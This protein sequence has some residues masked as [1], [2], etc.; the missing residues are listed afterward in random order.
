ML[1]TSFICHKQGVVNDE[2]LNDAIIRIVTGSVVGKD[3]FIFMKD[4][5][6]Q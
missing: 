4:L 1:A 3:Y 2:K 5:I 6:L